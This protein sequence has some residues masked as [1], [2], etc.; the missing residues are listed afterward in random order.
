MPPPLTASLSSALPV[1][2]LP[3][4]DRCCTARNI[5]TN[6]LANMHR[7]HYLRSKDG[8][9]T[10]PFDRGCWNNCSQFFKQPLARDTEVEW[11]MG[12]PLL[13]AE[14]T[15]LLSGGQMSKAMSQGNNGGVAIEMRDVSSS[16]S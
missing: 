5:T 6:E 14:L 11:A 4:P 15:A 13:E 8:R 10:N 2:L 3:T 7:Y 9:F 12:P 1:P 16:R